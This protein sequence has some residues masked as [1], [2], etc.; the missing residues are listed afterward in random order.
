MIEIVAATRTL[1]KVNKTI[2]LTIINKNKTLPKLEI[3]AK[4]KIWQ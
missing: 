2:R 3:S 4:P 1:T